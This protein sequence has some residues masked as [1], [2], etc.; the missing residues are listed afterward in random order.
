M[1]RYAL[2]ARKSKE[3]KSG[4]IKSIEDQ[5]EISTQMAEHLGLTIQA[6]YEENKTAKTPGV[7]PV[8]NEMVAAIRAG[9]INALLVW[10]VNRLARNMEEAGILAQLL[11][12]GKIREIRTPHTLYRPGD[13]ILPL[14]LEQGMSTQYSLDL[15]ENVKRGM[16]SMVAS[17]GWPHQAKVGYLNSRDPANPNRGIVIK[18]S[19]R[20]DTVRRAFDLM[21]KGTHSVRRVV[22][23]MNEEWGFRTRPTPTRPDS[24][25]SYATAY[26]M[27]TN[28]FYAGF[29]IHNGVQRKGSHPAMLTI[30]EY[31]RLQ[32]IMRQKV[33]RRKQIHEFAYT[34][35]FRCGYC[36]Y[37]IT[38]ERHQR[39][40]SEW[41]YYHCS[42]TKLRCTKKGIN[43]RDLEAILLEQLARIRID[44]DVCEIAWDNIARWSGVDIQSTKNVIDRQET[45]L[46]N[47]KKQ[48]ETLL[49]LML[50]G[51][52]TDQELYRTKERDLQTAYNRLVE[53]Q[54]QA[55]HQRDHMRA[56]AKAGLSYLR[57]A[58][59]RMASAS[60][61]QKGEIIRALAGDCVLT[62]KDVSISLNPLLLEL[63]HY[64]GKIKAK[65]ELVEMK[66]GSHK[67]TS[68]LTSSYV[69]RGTQTLLEPPSSLINTLRNSHFPILF[70]QEG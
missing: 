65:L 22:D 10:H 34:G 6:V 20:F 43:E 8:Y 57:F 60:P 46:A 16:N 63:V 23:I 59:V 2:Y 67:T 38:G 15:S 21:L 40:T 39:G 13:N 18:D 14:L 33:R 26:D 70:V 50:Q 62:G 41:V 11:I 69:G 54:E 49:E 56:Q 35:I 68:F 9:K 12:D 47:I 36:G 51:V 66:S 61:L 27:F 7:R 29:T 19:E 48:R 37:Q 45:A 64:T 4:L 1:L 52:L 58:H 25:L 53:E 55:E 32:E 17:G 3:D 44:E 5:K 30:A 24:P 42:D 28:P 31:N